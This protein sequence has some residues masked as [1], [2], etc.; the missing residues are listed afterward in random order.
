MEE[1]LKEKMRDWLFPVCVEAVEQV[2]KRH[3][4]EQNSQSKTTEAK[5]ILLDSKEVCE[6]LHISVMTLNRMIKKGSLSPI[7]RDQKKRVPRL[8][9]KADIDSYINR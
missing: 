4:Q 1:I 7:A 6:R 9:R 2:L 5:E 8:F 3:Y